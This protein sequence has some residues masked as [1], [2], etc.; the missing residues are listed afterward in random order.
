MTFQIIDQ[1]EILRSSVVQIRNERI[2]EQGW[3][4][5]T[6]EGVNDPRMGTTERDRLCLTCKG[7][8]VDC[9]G[10]FGHI[11]LAKP[12]Y[13]MGYIDSLVKILRCVCFNCS[14]IL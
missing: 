12:M 2:Y 8:N 6:L 10:H 9:P 3:L 14:K 4:F 5:P 7:S 1:D 11:E 13:H